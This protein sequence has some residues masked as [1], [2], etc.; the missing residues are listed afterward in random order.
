ML[1]GSRFIKYKVLWEF[2]AREINSKLRNLK[3]P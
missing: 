1:K 2:K 3:V